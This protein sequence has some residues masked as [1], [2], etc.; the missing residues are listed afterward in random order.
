MPVYC[1]PGFVDKSGAGLIGDA[2]MEMDSNIGRILDAVEQ[3]GIADNT[4]FMFTSDNGPEYRDPW[5]GTAGPWTGCYNTAMEGSLRTPFIIRWPGHFPG[6]R[7]S[8]EIVHITDLFTTLARAAGAAV[9]TDRA[10]DGVDQMD[11]F[12][13]KQEKSNRDSFP[14][15]LAGALYAVKWG[16]WKLHYL[17]KPVADAQPENLR[18][19]FNLRRDPKEETNVFWQNTWVD[20]R[21]D[22]IV[23]EFMTDLDKHPLIKPG[24]PDPYHPPKK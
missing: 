6:G 18:R 12:T 22:K 3:A 8:N 7:V 17:W 13:G 14:V 10:I 11:F 20:E 15:Y 9:P 23:A 24:T 2:V 1:L 5:R 21:I 19:L 16:D 4:I